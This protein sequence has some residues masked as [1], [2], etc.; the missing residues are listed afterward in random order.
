MSLAAKTSAF[1]ESSDNGLVTHASKYAFDETLARLKRAIDATGDFQM[2][3]NVDHAA[4]AAGV[5]SPIRPMV[6][7]LFANPKS[8]SALQT[9]APTIGIDLPMRALVWENESGST[10]VT[11]NSAAWLMHRHGLSDRSE[12]ISR[13]DSL[14]E[15][16][17]RAA[18]E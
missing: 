10:F 4:A 8:G 13:L 7:V 2:L 17:S 16:L 14:F 1:G 11:M 12:N 6:L 9:A 5:G 18:T 15:K 3:Y